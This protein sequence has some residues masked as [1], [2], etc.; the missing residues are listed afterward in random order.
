[1]VLWLWLRQNNSQATW[2]NNS[3]VLALLLVAME[4]HKQ[5]FRSCNSYGDLLGVQVSVKFFSSSKGDG[6]GGVGCW[7]W[8]EDEDAGQIGEGLSHEACRGHPFLI[9]F[10][11][12]SFTIVI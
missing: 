1:M 6:D 3:N 12:A 8:E 2:T 10:K 5:C 7:W 4:L 9:I 11:T